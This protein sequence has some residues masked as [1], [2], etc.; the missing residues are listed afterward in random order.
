MSYIN[1]SFSSNYYVKVIVPIK[2]PSLLP[3]SPEFG[4]F[5]H[6]DVSSRD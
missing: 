1:V 6:V 3:Y 4:Q 5:S 2:H